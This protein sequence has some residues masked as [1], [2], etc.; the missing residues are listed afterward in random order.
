MGDRVERRKMEKEDYELTQVFNAVN[1]ESDRSAV[2]V[3]A[4]HLSEL[5]RRLIE[6]RLLE[7]RG[8]RDLLGGPAAPLQ[9]FSAR[10]SAAFALG[11]IT[12]DE[13]RMLNI[14]RRIR[15]G[16]AHDARASFRDKD[17]VARCFLF[18]PSVPMPETDGRNASIIK[19]KE[20]GREQFSAHANALIILLTV[21]LNADEM[22]RLQTIFPER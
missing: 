13:F 17:L 5:L 21:R 20:A 12:E 3:A 2:V 11:L 8:T 18:D 15:N 6:R 4:S 9:S 10:S 14:V 1:N 22:Q 7:N 19:R 16:F